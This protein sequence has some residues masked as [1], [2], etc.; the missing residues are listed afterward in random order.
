MGHIIDHAITD[1][2]SDGYF[3]INPVTR[4]ITNSGPTKKLTLIKNDHNSE[5]F[6]FELPRM[7]E[8]HDMSLC[9]QVT[10][11]FIN[12]GSSRERSENVYTIYKRN[13]DDPEPKEDENDQPGMLFT[14]ERQFGFLNKDKDGNVITD[15]DKQVVIGTWLISRAATEYRGTLSFVVRFECLNTEDEISLLYE[16]EVLM[17]NNG[18]KVK[19]LSSSFEYENGTVALDA[20]SEVTELTLND[21]RVI[22]LS[23]DGYPQVTET[24]FVVDYSW[25]SAIYSKISISDTHNNKEEVIEPYHDVL[26][27]WWNK[28]CAA[29]NTLYAITDDGVLLNVTE[30]IESLENVVEAL[31]AELTELDVEKRAVYNLSYFDGNINTIY[32]SIDEIPEK[33]K[34][35]GSTTLVYQDETVGNKINVYSYNGSTWVKKTSLR[36]NTIYRSLINNKLYCYTMSHPYL[37]EVSDYNAANTY[38]DG[39]VSAAKSELSGAISTLSNTVNGLP[40]TS[41]TLYKHDVAIKYTPKSSPVATI[42]SADLFSIITNTDITPS[43]ETVDNHTHFRIPGEILKMTYHKNV[44]SNISADS[45][46]ISESD[47]NTVGSP[48]FNSSAYSIVTDKNGNRFSDLDYFWVLLQNPKETL[49]NK[50]VKITIVNGEQTTTMDAT[51]Q[52]PIHSEFMYIGK[53]IATSQEFLSVTTIKTTKL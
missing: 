28:I 35:N 24:K 39:A 10:V 49:V 22:S 38:T 8:G 2:Q 41:T 16:D 9:N 18:D 27:Q 1:T 3:H 50:P 17:L 19:V 30:K 47:F 12:I 52:V 5:V 48:A 43:I 15:P 51:I 29:S 44:S 6:T 34:S 14:E 45:L 46:S 4:E 37:V 13:V 42:Y 31:N 40:T 36:S 26:E 7:I 25:S 53:D 23:E 33:Q 20:D 21:G 32:S 11:H